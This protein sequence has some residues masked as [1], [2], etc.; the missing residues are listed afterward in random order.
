MRLKKLTLLILLL[1]SF[2]SVRVGAI[3]TQFE[4]SSPQLSEGGT[5]PQ[6]MV[7]RG[8]GCN[9]QNLSPE[10]SWTGEPTKTKSYAIT[11]FDPDAP[12]GLGW[13]HWLVFNL[14]KHIHTI[15]EGAGD[16]AANRLPSDSQQGYTDFGSNGYGG[17]CPPIGNTPHRYIL[18]IYALDIE[19]LPTGAETTGAKL[20]FLMRGH[21]LGKAELI[22][23]Y[24]R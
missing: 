18:T 7:Y 22:G 13:Q 17:A 19:R 2:T 10:L 11:M 21:I 20:A 4:L 16:T 14:P 8:F 5:L 23:R 15:S 9:G 24:G 6:S 12:T 3:A 1:L